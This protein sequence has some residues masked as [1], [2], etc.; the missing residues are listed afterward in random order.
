MSR[1]NCATTGHWRLFWVEDEKE[2]KVFYGYC[3]SICL[4]CSFICPCL[5]EVCQF[6][7]GSSNLFSML[8]WW[9][10]LFHVK[11][12]LSC[13]DC[14]KLDRCRFFYGRYLDRRP[15]ANIIDS[16]LHGVALQ[17]SD[18]TVVQYSRF[19]VTFT[20]DARDY[21]TANFQWC[22]IFIFEKYEKAVNHK[23]SV[24]VN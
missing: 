6:E 11:T 5:S 13:N 8:G 3:N 20:I 7:Y 19:I 18:K 12:W 15:F 23:C 21:R 1:S 16:F 2:I 4:I 17:H 10:Q 14:S 24:V 9:T 22:F